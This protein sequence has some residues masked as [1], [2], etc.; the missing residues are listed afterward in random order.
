MLNLLA[1]KK[2]DNEVLQDI[3]A[4]V[5]RRISCEAFTHGDLGIYAV[6]EVLLR[7]FPT[8]PFMRD[9]MIPRESRLGEAREV[10]ELCR[11]GTGDTNLVLRGKREALLYNLTKLI[12]DTSVPIAGVMNHQFNRADFVEAFSWTWRMLEDFRPSLSPQLA[13]VIDAHVLKPPVPFNIQLKD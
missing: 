10:I 9:F 12:L 1:Y 11:P 8:P 2:G 3:K 6:F 13:E 5:I 4:V 7:D